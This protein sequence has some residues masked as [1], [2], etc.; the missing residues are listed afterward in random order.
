M[1][2]YTV[3]N[4]TDIFDRLEKI[5]EMQKDPTLM[6]LYKIFTFYFI[7]KPKIGILGV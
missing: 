5:K 1:K 7:L 3:N 4:Y 2:N 6:I